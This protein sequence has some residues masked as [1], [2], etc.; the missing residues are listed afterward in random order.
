MPLRTRHFVDGELLAE[1]VPARAGKY[2]TPR[3]TDPGFSA[4]RAVPLPGGKPLKR[5][6]SALK[7]ERRCEQFD[8]WLREAGLQPLSELLEISCM[9]AQPINLALHG[10]GRYL[11]RCGAP[12]SAYVETC[13]GI[14]ML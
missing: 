5:A 11:W 4:R 10:F 3:F 7:M 12:R 1:R 8:E 13:N 9:D 6:T 14:Q 2:G